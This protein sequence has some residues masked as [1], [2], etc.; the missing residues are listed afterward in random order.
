MIFFTL[1]LHFSYYFTHSLLHT[2]SSSCPKNNK[3]ICM[4]TDNVGNS[5][6]TNNTNSNNKNNHS[7]TI[8]PKQRIFQKI[9]IQKNKK[10]WQSNATKIKHQRRQRL[11]KKAFPSVSKNNPSSFNDSD[12]DDHHDYSHIDDNS[13]SEDEDDDLLMNN[14]RN[15]NNK[16]VCSLFLLL[17]Y[18]IHLISIQSD[19]NSPS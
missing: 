8:N 12:N 19:A 13:D 4:D 16:P 7:D 14:K 17:F 1:L 11:I 15:I 3:S 5:S 9:D 6:N 10:Q 2:M 18:L